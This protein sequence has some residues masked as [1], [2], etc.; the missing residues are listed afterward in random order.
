MLG[1]AAARARSLLAA[2]PRGRANGPIP[3]APEHFPRPR[4]ADTSAHR[5][6]GRANGPIPA[7]PEHFARPRVDE[8]ELE[9]TRGRANGRGSSD[10]EHFARPRVDETGV[11]E[12]GSDEHLGVVEAVDWGEGIGASLRAGLVEARARGASV[13]VVT[14][15]DL[16]ELD[17]R[18]IARVREGASSTTLR[19]AVYGGRPG[20]PVVIGS[21]H[22]NELVSELRGDVGARP[23]LVAHG[24]EPVDCTDLGGG[25]D[26]DSPER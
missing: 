10:F 18:A 3:P 11:D 9:G 23:Y 6:R 1:A 21:G 2:S 25:D 4:V 24:V 5:D 22:F 15:V 16:P 8:T 26:V 19:Q 12:T 14:L 7:D 13:A 17:A 20:H